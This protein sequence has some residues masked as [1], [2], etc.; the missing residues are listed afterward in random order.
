MVKS[1]YT[2]T[3][4]RFDPQ[5]PHQVA[6][7]AGVPALGPLTP[8]PKLLRASIFTLIYTCRHKHAHIFLY[9]VY[10]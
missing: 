5:H 2:C 3:G 4:D 10:L 9:C 7:V 8:S 1:F 6:T